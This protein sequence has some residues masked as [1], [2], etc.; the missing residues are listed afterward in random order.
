[1]SSV[2]TDGRTDPSGLMKAARYVRPLER[3]RPNNNLPSQD[4]Q[5][6][7]TSATTT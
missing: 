6:S 2:P 1:M 5:P 7:R 4:A 3:R